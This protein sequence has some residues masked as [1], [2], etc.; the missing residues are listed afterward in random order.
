MLPESAARAFASVDT[1][2]ND[3]SDH[4]KQNKV[5]K[6]LKVTS[7]RVAPGPQASPYMCAML[8][9]ASLA[10]AFEPCIPTQADRAPSGPGWLHEIKHDG[11]RLI[12]RRDAGGVRLLTRNGHDFTDRY[13][14]VATAAGRLRCRSC[15]IDGE[16]VICGPDGVAIFDRLQKGPRVKPVAFMFAFD[17]L[18]LNGD[19]LRR[20]PLVNRKATL[21]S[22]L[23]GHPPGIAFVE[24]IEGDGP[25]IFRHAC[26][27]GCE[28]IV[29]KRADS[30]Y[31]SGRTR[32]W[33]KAKSPAAIAEQRVRSE[34]WNN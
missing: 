26:K 23:K 4:Q 19:N 7:P 1:N 14:T 24:H 20:E 17:L 27:L 13:P 18:E 3:V 30:V 16:V 10:I 33:I 31:R 29:S 21:K 11:Y 2:P 8:P 6:A 9:T 15:I 32:D 12:A 22:L 5:S 28:G 34:N 25:T